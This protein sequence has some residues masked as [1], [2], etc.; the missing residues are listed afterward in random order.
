MDCES[1]S[2]NAGGFERI[3]VVVVVVA[4]IAVGPFCVGKLEHGDVP[5]RILG[6]GDG[7]EFF[8]P[9][10]VLVVVVVVVVVTTNCVVGR[11]RHPPNI[12]H[13]DGLE[14]ES[15]DPYPKVQYLQ[16]QTEIGRKGHQK[17]HQQYR[18]A[19]VESNGGKQPH[20]TPQ[21]RQGRREWAVISLAAR[22]GVVDALRHQRGGVD[23][24][25]TQLADRHQMLRCDRRQVR[26]SQGQRT[27]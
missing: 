20:G 27:G 2:D 8:V 14:G 17:G 19:P 23:G 3:V 11:C 9:T 13:I 5:E 4:L 16:Q 1:E 21:S 26:H 25:R 10:N 6:V 24:H 15:L 12:G 7:L 22:G 18:I